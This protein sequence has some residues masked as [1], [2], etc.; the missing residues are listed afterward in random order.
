MD[1]KTGGAVSVVGGGPVAPT[2]WLRRVWGW[3]DGRLIVRRIVLGTTLVL[4]CDS[5]W[6][7]K[8]YASKSAFA[9]SDLALV[10]GAV[11]APVVALQGWAFRVYSDGR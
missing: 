11:L 2:S 10:V 8:Q 1:D 7:A 5:F 4:T 6:W 3:V 9:G